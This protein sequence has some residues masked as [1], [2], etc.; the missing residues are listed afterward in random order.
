[1]PR[2]WIERST[3]IAVRFAIIDE[4]PTLTNGSGMPGD[5][6]DAH[7][8]PDV[9]EDLEE[10]R[11]DDAARDDRGEQVAG[12]GD[13]PQAPPDDEQVQQE[14]DRRADEAALLRERGEDEV[15]RVLRQVREV[16]LRRACHAAS[17]EAAG[18]DGDVRLRDVVGRPARVGVRVQEAGP[19]LSPGTA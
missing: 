10:K 4:P 11:D 19:A 7:R 3:P 15:G 12:D 6:R 5:R 14:Q 13:D 1:M 9:D 16:R 2:A 17:V 8:H 18:A